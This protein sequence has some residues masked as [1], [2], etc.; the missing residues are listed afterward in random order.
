MMLKEWRWGISSTGI[1][2]K[3]MVINGGCDRRIEIRDK[4]L[5]QRQGYG[6]AAVLKLLDP[7]ICY[8]VNYP[9]DFDRYGQNF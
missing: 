5:S 2:G 6:G 1:N 9:V 3:K 4:V 7:S 8:Y